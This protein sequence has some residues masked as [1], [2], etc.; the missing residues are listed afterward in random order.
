VTAPVLVVHGGGDP[1]TE[2]GELDRIL[3][4]L[5]DPVLSFHPEAGHSPHSEAS[6]RD[7]VT[8]AVTA[9]LGSLAP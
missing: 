3:A 9:F 1:R 6:T 4:V 2:P 5:P 8:R 7:A